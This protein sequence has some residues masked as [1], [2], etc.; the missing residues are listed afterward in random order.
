LEAGETPEASAR[1]GRGRFRWR[2]RAESLYSR[3]FKAMDEAPPPDAPPE[4]LAPLDEGPYGLRGKDT[5][6]LINMAGGYGIIFGAVVLLPLLLF[7]LVRFVI[8]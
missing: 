4:N 3:R 8:L 1:H 6:P 2:S 7:L 5:P